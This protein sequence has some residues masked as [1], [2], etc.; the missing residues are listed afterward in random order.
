MKLDIKLFQNI[1]YNKKRILFILLIVINDLVGTLLHSFVL[2]PY[3]PWRI[4]HSK[5]HMNT[6]SIENDES[7]TIVF[8]KNH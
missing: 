4:S 8:N 3:H 2:T 6:G 7:H 5:H 1:K